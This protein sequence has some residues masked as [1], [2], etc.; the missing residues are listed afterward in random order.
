MATSKTSICNLALIHLG[1]SKLL[2]NVETDQTAAA[3]ACRTVYDQVRNEVLRDFTWPFA[4]E[5]VTLALVEADPNDEWDYAYRYPDD[6]IMFHRI[7]NDDRPTALITHLPFRLGQ[8]SQGALIFTDRENAMGQYTIRIEDPSRYP[9][10][11]VGM[12]ALLLAVYLAPSVTAGDEFKLGERAM[13]V[14][15]WARAI[16]RANASNEEQ[17]DLD[18]NESSFERERH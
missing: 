12:L 17:A 11:F 18:N 9:P 6:C 7:L 3:N 14:Y 8:D 13:K 2:A 5:R 15:G 16:A 4:T 10:D 1:H